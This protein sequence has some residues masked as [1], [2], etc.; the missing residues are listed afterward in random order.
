MTAEAINDDHA[1]PTVM[2]EDVDLSYQ[3]GSYV[4]SKEDLEYDDLCTLEYLLSYF[5]HDVSLDKEIANL[6]EQCLL[7]EI[8]QLKNTIKIHRESQQQL[9]RTNYELMC[10]M[11]KDDDME[12]A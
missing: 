4:E 7:K 1:A 6:K 5:E 12:D 10:S 8:K 11:G 9:E 2:A 3:V